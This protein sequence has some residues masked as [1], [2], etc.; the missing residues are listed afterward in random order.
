MDSLIPHKSNEIE[1]LY[2]KD[3]GF[4]QFLPSYFSDQVRPGDVGTFSLVTINISRIHLTFVLSK[5]NKQASKSSE[6][7]KQSFSP[8]VISTLSERRESGDATLRNVNP[9]SVQSIQ[10]LRAAVEKKR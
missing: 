10:Q 7:C 2:F 6:H 8:W 4:I 5:Q 3:E 9:S 1:D